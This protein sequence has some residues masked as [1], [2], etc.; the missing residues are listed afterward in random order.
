MDEQAINTQKNKRYLYWFLQ[1]SGWTLYG[2]ITFLVAL[3]QGKNINAYLIS[4]I[5]F[6]MFTGIV[7]SELFRKIVIKKQWLQDNLTILL[8]RTIP[9]TFLLSL[10]AYSVQLLFIHFTN[11]SG[12]KF[13]WLDFIIGTM[14]WWILL[15]IWHLIYLIFHYFNKLRNEELINTRLLAAKA[16]SELNQL[17]TQINPHFIF[18][19]M[20]SIRA[21]VDESPENAKKAITQ[22]ANLLRK[23]LSLGQ[24]NLISV[25]E[26]LEIVNAYLSIE[27]IRFENRLQYIIEADEESSPYAIPPLLLQTLTENAVKH[28]ISHLTKGGE[29]R[30][31]CKYLPEKYLKITITNDIVPDSA[32]TKNTEGMGLSLVRK[33]MDLLYGKDYVFEIHEDKNQNK[34]IVEI[35]IP[36]LYP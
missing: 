34:I 28:G 20:N 14:N 25:K 30:L 35:F 1:L 6:I 5:M 29:I 2:F 3:T 9:L 21:L 18:N 15:I 31:T 23:T 13:S 24:R 19:S 12:I 33:R 4:G 11:P 7:T 27:K 16:Q 36:C 10:I 26:E 22:L 17:K 32:F 8:K